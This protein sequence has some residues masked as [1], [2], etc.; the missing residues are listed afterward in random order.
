MKHLLLS[1]GLCLGTVTAVLAQSE[2]HTQGKYTLTFVNQDP[3]LNPTVKQNLIKAFFQTYPA[4][5]KRFNKKTV[6]DVTVTIDTA[7]T[8]VAY[9]H[10]GKITIS[11]AWLRKRP[12]D[13]DVITHEGMHLVQAY[14][15]DSGPG[16]ITEG[17]ADYVRHTFGVDNA[18]ANWSLPEPT[19]K[20]NFDNSYRI[21]ARFLLWAE[22]HVNKKLVN[23]L[24]ARMRQKTYT[25]AAWKELT[26][27]TVEELWQA[28]KA[29]PKI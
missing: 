16:W 15:P 21:T 14:P 20:H 9:A 29:N 27:K 5:A 1:L 6:K 4:E 7:Y 28:Y 2:T 3:A 26:G 19:D 8:G 12:T 25:P 18:G 13:I 24:D 11:S 23:E 10:E 22:K 17:I